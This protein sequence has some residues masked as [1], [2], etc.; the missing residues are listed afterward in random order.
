[1]SWTHLRMRRAVCMIGVLTLTLSGC[2]GGGSSGGGGGSATAYRVT[3]LVADEDN[4]P[5]GSSMH[6]DARLVNP[7]GIAFN[8]EG[9]VWVSNGGTATST[10]YDG[11]GVQQSLIV[12][13][14]DEPTGITFNGTASDF[15]VSAGGRTGSA[16]FVFATE[17]GLIAAWSPDVDLTSTVTVYDGSAQ[18]K[19][20][21][22]LAMANGR[23]YATDFHN[24]RVD[25]FDS[26]FELQPAG[27]AFTDDTLPHGYAP[28]GIQAIGSRIYVSYAQQDDDAEDE[29]TGA[30]LG[31]INVFDRDGKL[32]K[33][34]VSNGPLNAPWG[35]AKAPNGF[36]DFSGALL[37]GNFGDGRINA[38]DPDTGA[39]LGPLR[40]ANGNPIKI[41]GLW[42]IAFGNGI[43]A[44]PKTT[45][46]YAAGP[47]DE[48][49]GRYGRIDLR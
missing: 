8:P 45:L 39:S 42:G 49:H 28:F 12:A 43:N 6:V 5:Y 22:G 10:L 14:P 40:D 34:L 23:L 47:G 46:F 31:F 3:G 7:W 16:A 33:R 36:G 30:G 13:T 17:E 38:F 15:V 41:E 29:V 20:Y 2:G 25:V 37:V 27:T 11:N 9:F 48:T 24:G 21:L 26:G 1:M 19:V 18:D 35:M 32:L 44:Q 4:S